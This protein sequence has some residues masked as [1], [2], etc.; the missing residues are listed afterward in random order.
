MSEDVVVG[1]PRDV[2]ASLD[3]PAGGRGCV[4]ACPPHPQA[5]GTRSNPVLTALGEA[6]ADRELATLRF[7]YGPWDDGEGEVADAERAVDWAAER[8][9]AVG[10]F[11]FS[12]GATVALAAAADREVVGVVALSP[13]HRLP[14]L[15]T[16]A[17]LEAVDVPV[18]LLYG[19]RDRVVDSTPV[20]ERAREL[21]HEVAALPAD[22]HFVGQRGKVAGRAADFLADRF[23]EGGD[24]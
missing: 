24:P 3:G 9:G 13:A 20:A 19:E 16:V 6:L 18:L 17:V 15:D 5:G 21:G 7:D 14:T 23:D 1:G 2:R 11:G 4:V 10:L 8:Y 22:H 12:F